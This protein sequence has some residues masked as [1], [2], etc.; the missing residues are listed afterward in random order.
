MPQPPRKPVHSF[1]VEDE[2]WNAAVRV[3]TERQ[4]SLSD[5]LRR[6][7]VRY[8]KKNQSPENDG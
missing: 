4:E 2:I 5:V 6:A 3:A 1:R 7:L 8:V